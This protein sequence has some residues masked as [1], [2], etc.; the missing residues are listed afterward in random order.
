MR[1]VYILSDIR[2]WGKEST[3]ALYRSKIGVIEINNSEK[4]NTTIPE[5]LLRYKGNTAELNIIDGKIKISLDLE[6]TIYEFI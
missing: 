2:Y 6:E 1:Y 3:V 4:V 5:D